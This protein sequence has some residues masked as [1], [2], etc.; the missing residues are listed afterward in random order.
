MRHH[1]ISN[2]D[3]IIDS[4]DV[5]AR[6]SELEDERDEYEPPAPDNEGE[7]APTWAELN[8]EDAAELAALLALQDE[9]EGRADWKFSETLI[10]DSYFEDYAKELAEN[11]GAV[12]DDAQWPYSCIDWEMAARELQYDYT[13]VDFA[14]ETY[15]I[16]S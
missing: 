16:R 8:E 5:I 11:I 1:T 13:Q 14:G 4:R 12:K 7:T 9:A 2:T 10:H 15:W 3:S 6:I